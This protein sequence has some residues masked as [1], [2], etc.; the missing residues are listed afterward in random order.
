MIYSKSSKGGIDIMKR[1][2]VSESPLKGRVV[3]SWLL[4][5]SSVAAEMRLKQLHVITRHGSRYALTKTQTLVEGTGEGTLTPLGQEQMFDLGV[6][7]RTFYTSSS[8]F[9]LFD[10]SK[11][12]LQSSAFERT[13]TSANSLALGF[14]PQSARDPAGMSLL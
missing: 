3:V 6:W 14:F 2:T 12:H 5:L 1:V 4:L 7:L 9:E 11:V 13:V 10:P 8:L